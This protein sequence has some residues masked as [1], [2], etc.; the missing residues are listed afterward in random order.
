MPNISVVRVEDHF[1]HSETHQYRHFSAADR[2]TPP[3][4]S[5]ERLD[6]AYCEMSSE[7]QGDPIENL[8]PDEANRIIH[9]H[10][11]VRYGELKPFRPS[12]NLCS[13]PAFLYHH[14]TSLSH[15]AKS[16]IQVPP[17]GP[18]GREK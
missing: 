15:L 5:F 10:R 13:E 1:E 8:T 7:G 17:A 9:S 6:I 2:L 11:K 12:I 16:N 3:L 14:P 18:A 4:Q